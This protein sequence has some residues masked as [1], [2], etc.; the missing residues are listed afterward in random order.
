MGAGIVLF[1]VSGDFLGGGW[2]TYEFLID[3]EL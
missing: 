1:L 3:L 2:V